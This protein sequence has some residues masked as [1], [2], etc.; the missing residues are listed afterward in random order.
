MI[1]IPSMVSALVA[2]A[3]LYIIIF[4]NKNIYDRLIYSGIIALF[5]IMGQVFLYIT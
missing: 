4:E 2:L 5:L 3:M 1:S